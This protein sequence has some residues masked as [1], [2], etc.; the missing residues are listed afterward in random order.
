MNRARAAGAGAV[1]SVAVVTGAVLVSNSRGE[2]TLGPGETAVATAAEAPRR[3]DDAA[4]DRMES[5]ARATEKEAEALQARVDDLA[6]AGREMLLRLREREAA[7]PGASGRT[8]PGKSPDDMMRATM[9]VAMKGELKTLVD[10]LERKL[11]L[12]PEQRKR[13]EDGYQAMFEKVIEAFLS[14]EEF[15]ELG[16]GQ[17]QALAA[18]K[19]HL[20]ADQQE[21]LRRMEEEEAEA[22]RKAREEERAKVFKDAAADLRL[23]DDQ[24]ARLAVPLGET[25]QSVSERSAMLYV[26]VMTGRMKTEDYRSRNEA[27][28]RDGVEKLREG[29]TADQV[30][31]LRRHLEK[32]TAPGASTRARIAGEEDK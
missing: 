26:R 19:P 1:L 21:A 20:R 14:G 29:L 28:I 12:T 11:Q 10:K 31:A 8:K 7:P 23:T 13:A 24:R 4:L 16:D 6:R 5:E 3:A 9:R 25:L 2:V 22:A 17:D 27:L 15:W 32:I 30:E 18:L